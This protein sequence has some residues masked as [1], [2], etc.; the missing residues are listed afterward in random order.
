MLR[1][2]AAVRPKSKRPKTAA[3][4]PPSSGIARFFGPT[5][6]P[7]VN[8]FFAVLT[9][10]LPAE[11]HVLFHAVHDDGDEEDLDEEEV[12]ANFGPSP[13]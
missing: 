6:G 8:A 13:P 7:K 3:H 2:A 10:W 1:L 11:D 12:D 4:G 5:K 9:R